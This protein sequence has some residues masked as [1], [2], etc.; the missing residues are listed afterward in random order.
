MGEMDLVMLTT[1]KSSGGFGLCRGRNVNTGVVS[2]LAQTFGV[3]RTACLKMCV[4]VLFRF[5]V[6]LSHDLSSGQIQG[7]GEGEVWKIC[8]AGALC[9]CVCGVVRRTFLNISRR[10]VSGKWFTYTTASQQHWESWWKPWHYCPPV[11]EPGT[12]RYTRYFDWSDL[13]KKIY[14]LNSLR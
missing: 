10:F 7:A 14:I 11:V 12:D 5:A 13:L 6:N 3:F 9:E 4:C 1:R 8:S 2:A